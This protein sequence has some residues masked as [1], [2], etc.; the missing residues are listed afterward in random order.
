MSPLTLTCDLHFSE[1]PY[2]MKFETHYTKLS[3]LYGSFKQ[4]WKEV[5]NSE[6][7]KQQKQQNHYLLFFQLTLIDDKL[8][9]SKFVL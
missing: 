5:S 9:H 3:L 2:Y 8:Y 4:F 1:L 6:Q 7:E